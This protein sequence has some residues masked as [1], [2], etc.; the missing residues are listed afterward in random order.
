MDQSAQIEQLQ[1]QL[2]FS[3]QTAF[4]AMTTSSDLGVAM[5]FMKDSFAVESYDELAYRLIDTLTGFGLHCCVAL[6]THAGKTFICDSRDKVEMTR[7]ESLIREHALDGRIVEFKNHIQVNYQKSSLLARYENIDENRLGQLRDILALLMDGVEA[8]VAS[9]ILS[10]QAREARQSKD[11]F[12]ALMSHELRTPLNP[13]IGFTG[14]MEKY[15]GRGIDEKFGPHIRNMKNCAES[16]LRLLN[17]IIDLASVESGSINLHKQNFDVKEAIDRACI[18]VEAIA[19]NKETD[20][21]KDCNGGITFYAD[22]ARF[23]DILISVL[24]YSI[25]ASRQH[26]VT[27]RALNTTHNIEGETCEYLK[28]IVE[29]DGETY[30]ESYRTKL[31]SNIT[32]RNLG[33]IY[34][35]NDLGIGLFL[36]KKLIEMHDGWISLMPVESGGN[37]FEIYFPA[38]CLTKM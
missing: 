28:V 24:S 17:H 12:F 8:R 3:Q 6:D 1:N 27:I 35:S 29:D 10:E 31:F 19:S 15:I 11:E 37:R 14:R 25:N 20:V 16:L 7:S 33:S 23:I 4:S 18:K 32:E 5:Q 30:S 9:L 13:I 26:T 22:I 34:E 36:T 2:E 21:V 38:Y